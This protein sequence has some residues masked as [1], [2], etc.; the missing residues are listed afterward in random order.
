MLP[1]FSFQDVIWTASRHCAIQEKEHRDGLCAFIPPRVP[2]P[3][4]YDYV[5]ALQMKG[6]AIV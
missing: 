2:R 3:I 4:L 5:A 6:L 1:A